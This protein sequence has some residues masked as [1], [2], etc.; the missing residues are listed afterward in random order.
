MCNCRCLFL[1]NLIAKK[2]IA[3]VIKLSIDIIINIVCNLLSIFKIKHHNS[4]LH[5]F[6][7]RFFCT[8]WFLLI[9]NIVCFN[10]SFF[11]YLW[12][13]YY[14][15]SLSTSFTVSRITHSMKFKCTYHKSPDRF[16][17]LFMITC[18]PLFMY[19]I[20]QVATFIQLFVFVII[21]IIF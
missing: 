17:I 2:K 13:Y 8:T 14:Y 9:H 19:F 18:I 21:I 7:D 6:S 10:S 11:L 12:L 15:L 5:I 1:S 3:V 20:L 16:Q 4:D